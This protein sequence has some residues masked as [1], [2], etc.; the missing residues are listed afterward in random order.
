M[1]LFSGR[2]SPAAWQFSTG[3]PIRQAQGRQARAMR[4]VATGGS[5]IQDDP[6]WRDRSS[7]MNISTGTTARARRP[8]DGVDRLDRQPSRPVR[9]Y[10][11]QRRG[12]TWLKYP[13]LVNSRHSD[14]RGWLRRGCRHFRLRAWRESATLWERI[15]SRVRAHSCWFFR[16]TCLLPDDIMACLL[17]SVWQNG[18]FDQRSPIGWSAPGPCG[19]ASQ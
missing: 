8:S 2:K 11:G 4:T 15:R 9:A 1:T 12:A 16:G 5:P 18:V 7:S 10:R 19:G 13:R 17:R 3:R 6:H 14:P